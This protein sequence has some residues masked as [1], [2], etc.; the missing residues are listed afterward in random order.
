MKKLL[1]AGSRS[2]PQT[3]ESIRFI[4]EYME[5]IFRNNSITHIISGGASGADQIGEEIAK[6]R[7]LGLL[8]YTPDWGI[9]GKVAGLI[10]NE[11]MAKKCDLAFFIWDGV[12]RGTLN[13]M[14]HVKKYQKPSEVLVWSK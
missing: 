4:N 1:I 6:I 8:R 10:R 5:F 11:Q 2:I 14:S 12:S 7:N 13:C 3:P 9:Y